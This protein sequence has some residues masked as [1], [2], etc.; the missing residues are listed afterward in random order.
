MQI[1]LRGVYAD[2]H[3]AGLCMRHR[4]RLVS[5]AALTCARR[6]GLPGGAD[7]AQVPGRGAPAD[8]ARQPGRAHGRA[9]GRRVLRGPQPPLRRRPAGALARAAWPSSLQARMQRL[10][11]SRAGAAGGCTGGSAQAEHLPPHQC[12]LKRRQT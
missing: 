12:W 1:T 4:A 6:A 9:P 8:G 10:R 2:A 3:W 5:C 7:A 11:F